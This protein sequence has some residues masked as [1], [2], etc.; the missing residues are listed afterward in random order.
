MYTINYSKLQ[1]LHQDDMSAVNTLF[2]TRPMDPTL[3]CAKKDFLAM[4]TIVSWVMW[5]KPV[6][7]IA[8]RGLTLHKLF[9]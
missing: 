5:L 1:F 9:A 2:A 6:S 7:T 8:Y 4:D 3:V